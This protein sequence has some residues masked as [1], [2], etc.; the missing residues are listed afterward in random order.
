MPDIITRPL[1]DFSLPRSSNQHTRHIAA[2]VAALALRR[3]PSN[4]SNSGSSSPAPS[5]TQIPLSPQLGSVTQHPPHSSG[6]VHHHPT[7][8]PSSAHQLTTSPAFVYQP[9]THPSSAHQPTT[10]PSFSIHSSS[11]PNSAHPLSPP[12]HPPFSAQPSVHPYTTNQPSLHLPIPHPHLSHSSVSLSGLDNLYQPTL[13]LPGRSNSVYDAK[14]I[15]VGTQMIPD[16]ISPVPRIPFLPASC[17][18]VAGMA[19][20]LS[21]LGFHSLPRDV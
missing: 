8:H 6:S 17:S 12:I 5:L 7:T 1:H 2:A 9:T 3:Q 4:S 15:A 11:H 14:L 13:P 20:S 10:N 16:S 18:P 19:H 21:S